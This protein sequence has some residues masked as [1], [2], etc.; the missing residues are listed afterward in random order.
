MG[1]AWSGRYKRRCQ[2]TVQW[3]ASDPIYL[4]MAALEA[5]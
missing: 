4:I 2:T 3:A 1:T 5:K